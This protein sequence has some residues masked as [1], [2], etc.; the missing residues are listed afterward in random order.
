MGNRSNYVTMRYMKMNDA[1]PGMRLAYNMY[2]ADGHT[3]ICSGSILSAFYIKRLGEYGF[4]GVYINDELSEDIQIEPIITPELRTEGL[5]N[6]RNSDVDG[7]K[8][9]AKK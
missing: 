5:F 3:L 9:V 4:D 6:V 8:G 1:R 2:D 7:C